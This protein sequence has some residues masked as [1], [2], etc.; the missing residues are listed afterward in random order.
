VY[1]GLVFGCPVG[2]FEK[3]NPFVVLSAAQRQFDAAQRG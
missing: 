3:I 1:F 2:R